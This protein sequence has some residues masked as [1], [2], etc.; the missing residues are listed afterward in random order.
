MNAEPTALPGVFV[1]MSPVHSDDRGFFTE[2]YHAEKF[3]GIGLPT[4][5]AQDNHSRSVRHVLR[6][7]HFQLER[8]QG[9]LVHAV[10]GTIFDVAVD[11]RRSSPMYGKW[12]GVTLVAGDGRQLWIPEGFAHGFFVLSETAD[13]IYK[14]TTEYHAA[15]NSCIRWDDPAIGVRWPIPAG[16]TPIVS[17]ADAEAP[18]L[19][20]R[21]WFA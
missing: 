4:T 6:G 5:F 21:A 14:C 1:V 3:A 2:V 18:T 16:A 9:K 17:S 13:I 10:T 15:S 11:I 12:V 19:A 8:P 7:L 20:S